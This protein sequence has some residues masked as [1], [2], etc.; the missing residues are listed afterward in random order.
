M[1]CWCRRHQRRPRRPHAP[2]PRP[3][4]HPRHP[5]PRSAPRL[6]RPASAASPTAAACSCCP[7]TPCPACAPTSCS[8]ARRP[9]RPRRPPATLGLPPRRASPSRS[10]AS[11][12]ASSAALDFVRIRVI[13]GHAEP[14]ATSGASNLSSTV[15]ADGF[16]LVPVRQ[17]GRRPRRAR[18]RV[19]VRRARFT[20]IHLPLPTCPPGHTSH[21]R[22]EP[23]P[24]GRR[25]RRGPARWWSATT[26]DRPASK[27]SPRRAAR[28]GARRGRRRPGRRARLRPQQRRRLRGPRRGQLRRQRGRPAPPGP[29]P[30]DR[31]R[32]GRHAT[33]RRARSTRRPRRPLGPRRRRGPRP[34]PPPRRGRRHRHR[35]RGPARRRRGRHGRAHR[36]V[37]GAPELLVRRPVAPGGNVTFAGTDIA[38]RRNRAAPGHGADVARDRRAGGDGRRRGAGRR[39]PRVGDPL[40]RRRDRRARRAARGPA[41]LRLQRHHPRRRRARAGRRAGAPRH[42]PATTTRRSLPRSR[43]PSTCDA[44]ICSSPAARRKGAGDLSLPGRDRRARSPRARRSSPTASRSSRASRCASAVT[45][46]PAQ[47]PW[48][49][50]RGFRPRRSSPSTSSSPRCCAAWPACRRREGH[51]GAS[52]ALNSEAAGASTYC[53]SARRHPSICW[54]PVTSPERPVASRWAR[55]GSVTAFGGPTASSRSGQQ[56]STDAGELVA[57]R[58]CIGRGVQACRPGGDRQPLRRPRAFRPAC[59]HAPGPRAKSDR[60]AAGRRRGGRPRRVRPRAA[61]TCST[62][63]LAAT[64]ATSCPTAV[65]LVPGYGRMQGLVYRPGDERFAALG[66]AAA[67]AAARDPACVWSTATAAAAPGCCSMRLLGTARPARPAGYSHEARSHAGSPPASPRAAPTGAWR[68]QAAARDAELQFHARSAR[69]ATTS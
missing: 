7:A 62:R 42:R 45:A 28:P 20:V 26:P 9:P 8:S 22:P 11:S 52:P 47:V 57:S 34:R 10:P 13:A 37:D 31:D 60:S 61:S 17:R 3:R 40:H 15:I 44:A 49:S 29:P 14:V 48:S 4:R 63:R 1:S 36:R 33:P 24:G 6:A 53:P 21:D 27:P 35:R 2:S 65:T 58:S 55:V 19:P 56:P 67:S 66:A 43:A 38:P 50:C 5:R 68:S 12:P 32:P 59:L 41:G 25:R 69:S 18:R 51:H 46:S 64:T 16:T 39:R 30:T 54:R 23:I